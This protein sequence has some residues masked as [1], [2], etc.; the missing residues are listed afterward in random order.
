[1]QVGTSATCVHAADVRDGRTKGLGMSIF[2]AIIER[3]HFDRM[4]GPPLA[5]A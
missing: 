5:F 2:R 3:F 4:G 1:M